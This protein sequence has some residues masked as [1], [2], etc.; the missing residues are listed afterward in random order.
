[1][2]RRL[3]VERILSGLL[4]VVGA[5]VLIFVT[6]HIVPG[7]PVA[8]MLAGAPA[9][10]SK[11]SELREE[12]GVDDPLPTQ[13]LDFV[14]GAMRGDLGRSFTTNQPV[15]E[16]ITEAIPSTLELTFASLAV[17]VVLGGAA[18]VL[19]AVRRGTWV[20]SVTRAAGLF[21]AS[22]PVFW[23]GVL[24]LMLFSFRFH[25][26][27]AIG[28]TGIKGIVLPAFSLG[29]ISAGVLSRFVRTCVL[30]VLD[31]PFVLALD[32][33]GLSRRVIIGKHV[34]RNALI[35]CVTVLGIQLGYALAGAV[36]TETL[37]SRQ[38]IGRLLVKAVSA[39]DYPLVQGLVLVVATVYVL[40]NLVVDVSYTYIDPR[41]RLAVERP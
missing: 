7:D 39:R 32:A 27:P 37:F 31:Q 22:M 11:I 24:L 25:L 12:L 19:A 9:S 29:I 34:L 21:G 38:G 13:Y 40:V 33:R 20:D 14:R 1:M 6:L 28:G 10:P 2:L 26:F 8:A 18:G 17:G 4:V 41:I 36:V 5:S 23:T 15:A 30:E 16:M 3:L 35:P